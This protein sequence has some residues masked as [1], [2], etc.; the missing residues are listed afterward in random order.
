MIFVPWVN[1][2]IKWIKIRKASELCPGDKCLWV[3]LYY[4]S[5]TLPNRA[6]MCHVLSFCLTLRMPHLPKC[7]RGR[8]PKLNEGVKPVSTGWVIFELLSLLVYLNDVFLPPVASP[9]G[10]TR[11]CNEP[12]APFGSYCRFTEQC[13]S[14]I[15]GAVHSAIFMEG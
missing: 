5:E 12:H 13:S 1:V 2:R 11:D 4:D 7:F 3:F 6:H 15:L 14:D 8:S 9:P 10:C